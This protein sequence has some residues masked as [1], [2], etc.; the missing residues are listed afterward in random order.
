[1]A[2]SYGFSYEFTQNLAIACILLSLV[3]LGSSIVLLYNAV[4]YRKMFI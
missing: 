1:L 4:K 2:Q 3:M